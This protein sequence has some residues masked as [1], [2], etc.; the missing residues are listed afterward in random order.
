ML[1]YA[2]LTAIIGISIFIGCNAQAAVYTTTNTITT[3]TV[4]PAPYCREY[5]QSVTI[6]GQTQTG[7][8]TACLQADGAWEI[9][10]LAP[11]TPSAGTVTTTQT[12]DQQIEYVARRNRV[13]FIPRAPFPVFYGHVYSHGHHYYH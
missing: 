7:V 3:T 4:A 8:G 13:Y 6:G 12:T 2:I 10:P 5:T 9:Q 1:K 11:T